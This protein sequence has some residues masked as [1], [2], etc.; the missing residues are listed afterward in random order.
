MARAEQE[1]ETKIEIEVRTS[2]AAPLCAHCGK[3]RASP[4]LGSDKTT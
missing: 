3:L 2:C 4:A 1:G